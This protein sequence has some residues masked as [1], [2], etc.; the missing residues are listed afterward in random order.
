MCSYIPSS[1]QICHKS[2]SGKCR[3]SAVRALLPSAVQVYVDGGPRDKQF[4]EASRFRGS[5]L[6][7]PATNM[8]Q[9]QI[10]SAIKILFGSFGQLSLRM[11]RK[12]IGM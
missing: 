8:Q 3:L 6:S 5:M 2:V 11:V 9:G 7:K 1:T 12:K 10:I 4:G